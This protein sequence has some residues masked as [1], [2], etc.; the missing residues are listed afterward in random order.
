MCNG[1]TIYTMENV[2][3]ENQHSV[4][5]HNKISTYRYLSKIFKKKVLKRVLK[6]F[7]NLELFEFCMKSY[8]I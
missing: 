1:N 8:G 4:S 2:L 7:K 3:D 5:A 6:T